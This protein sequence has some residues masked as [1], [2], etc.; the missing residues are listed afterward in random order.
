MDLRQIHATFLSKDNFDALLETIET[1]YEQL[2]G[3][4][5][6]PASYRQVGVRLMREALQ[7]TPPYRS[8]NHA[9]LEYLKMLNRRVLELFMK[10]LSSELRGGGGAQRAIQRDQ[11]IPPRKVAH[12]AD[13][14]GRGLLYRQTEDVQDLERRYEESMRSRNL[15]S[16]GATP[17][18]PRRPPRELRAE[19]PRGDD[20]DA[21]MRRFE[22]E[23]QARRRAAAASPAPTAA[24]P[25]VQ[26]DTMLEEVLQEDPSAVAL[27]P[28]EGAESWEEAF[29][30][31]R[32]EEE[33]EGT[34]QPS[35]VPAR[36]GTGLSEPDR[37]ALQQFR[38][39]LDALRQWQPPAIA[40]GPPRLDS[41][42][43]GT[44]LAVPGPLHVVDSFQRNPIESPLVWDL[45]VDFPSDW[46]G[47]AAQLLHGWI[48]R[49]PAFAQLP[50][51]RV[52][53][54]DQSV[55]C[56]LSEGTGSYAKLVPLQ[57]VDPVPV[58]GD[59]RPRVRVTTWDG[60]SIPS[61]DDVFEIEALSRN[62]SIDSNRWVIRTKA[63]V[64]VDT[65]TKTTAVRIWGNLAEP[66]LPVHGNLPVVRIQTPNELEIQ[67]AT[68]AQQNYDIKRAGT[69]LLGHRPVLWVFAK[70]DDRHKDISK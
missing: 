55:L 38:E 19:D 60:G 16:S 54:G 58:A 40:A 41:A 59:L 8:E 47:G 23:T 2:T 4:R 48:P 21:I 62:T 1:R 45:A 36:S 34:V 12:F 63:K 43:L 49:L 68:P 3:F 18:P 20:T 31:M 44:A 26:H 35:P 61:C 37:A 27:P 9:P 64:P 30:A 46:N 6:L 67:L 25:S 7:T 14:A 32:R 53:V 17:A 24:R 56:E 65:L 10:H 39:C 66:A 50:L 33:T 11:A 69:V 28:L 51:L 29:E 5:R 42:P 52:H 57:P 13:D 70:T 22:E 15:V